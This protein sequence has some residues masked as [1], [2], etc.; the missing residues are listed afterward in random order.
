[1]SK[2]LRGYGISLLVPFHCPEKGNQRAKNWRWLK[3]YWSAVL[4]GAEIVMGEDMVSKKKPSVPFSKSCAVNNAASKATGDIFVIVDADGYIHQNSILACAIKIRRARQRG[5]SLWFIPYRQFYRLTKQSSQKVLNSRPDKPY[6]FPTPPKSEDIQ[7]DS[8]SQYGHWWGAGIQIMPK[9]AFTLVGGWDERFRG[10]GGEDHAAMEAMDTLYWKHKTLPGK[11]L[12]IWH[13]MLSDVEGS[14]DDSGFVGW[15][16]RVWKNQ[17]T[18][19]ING[20]LSTRYYGA[21]GNKKRMQKL[22]D[23]WKK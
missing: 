3:K 12:H 13:P 8:G 6:R 1:M 19:G 21:Y 10:W 16:Y 14:E 2:Q 17:K 11:H 9:E 7:N 22:V 18:S 5:Q 20:K 4:P 15:K 23:E